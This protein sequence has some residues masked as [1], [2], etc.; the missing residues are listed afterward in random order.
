VDLGG[1]TR[2]GGNWLVLLQ[3]ASD[4]QKAFDTMPSAKI[5]LNSFMK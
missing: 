2:L 1:K 4:F 3:P 5:V